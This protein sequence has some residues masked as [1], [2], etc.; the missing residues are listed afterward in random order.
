MEKEM[1]AEIE[2]FIKSFNSLENSIAKYIFDKYVNKNAD[3]NYIEFKNNV[4]QKLRETRIKQEDLLV[5]DTDTMMLANAKYDTDN[6]IEGRDY[7]DL[8]RCTYIIKN[9]NRYSRCKNKSGD[10]GDRCSKHDDLP[11][12]YLEIY[13]KLTADFCKE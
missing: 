4:F 7:P 5:S 13:E 11:N 6:T 3:K 10:S 1:D 12:H 9:K 8:L 2:H